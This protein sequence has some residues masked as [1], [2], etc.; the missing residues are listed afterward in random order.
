MRFPHSLIITVLIFGNGIAFPAIADDIPSCTSAAG[1][2]VVAYPAEVPSAILDVLER[3]LAA[4]ALPGEPFDATDV[5]RT[6]IR[7]RLIWVKHTG[8]RW[9]VAWEN[10][11]RGYND[12]VAAFE[13]TNDGAISLIGEEYAFPPTVCAVTNRWLTT[14]QAI[15]THDRPSEK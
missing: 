8:S 11:G 12:K 1:A 7:H 5:V 14:H 9:V 15:A 10:G 2:A 4:F 6:G 13:L 3:R